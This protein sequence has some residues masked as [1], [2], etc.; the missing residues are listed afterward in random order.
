MND[1]PCETPK[2]ELER[3]RTRCW[4]TGCKRRAWL[5]DWKGWVTCLPHWYRSWRWGGGEVSFRSFI[6]ALK[7]TEVFL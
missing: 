5:R 2:E 4:N 3:Q 1:L 6:F 7:T